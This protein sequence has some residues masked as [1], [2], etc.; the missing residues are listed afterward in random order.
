[1]FDVIKSKLYGS[2]VLSSAIVLG[3]V[4]R[5]LKKLVFDNFHAGKGKR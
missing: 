5:V 2:S 1:M 3:R 4:Y